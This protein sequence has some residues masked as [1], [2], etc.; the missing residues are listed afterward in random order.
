MEDGGVC[1]IFCSHRYPHTS[2]HA[3]NYLPR[4]LKGADLVV[5]TTLHSFGI[6]VDVLPVMIEDEYD[7]DD[8]D[9][10]DGSEGRRFCRSKGKSSV[11]TKYRGKVHIGAQ[12]WPH[13]CARNDCEDPVSTVSGIESDL[14]QDEAKRNLHQI[15]M[16]Y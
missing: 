10:T 7:S 13:Q 15:K 1:G 16:L 4:G 12:L 9:D 8:S 11:H 2:H 5:Y 6:Q 3:R 14:A